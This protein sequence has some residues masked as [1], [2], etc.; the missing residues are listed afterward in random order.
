MNFSYIFH[1]NKSL[2]F[3][4]HNS[5]HKN[6]KFLKTFPFLARYRLYRKASQRTATNIYKEQMAVSMERSGMNKQEH[7]FEY[8]IASYQDLIF[9]L[10]YRMTKDYFSAEDLT[11]DTFLSAYQSLSKFDQKQERA[12]L[13]RIATNKCLDY[14]KKAERRAIPEDTCFSELPS[15]V[16]SPEEQTL[17]QEVR[18]ELFTYCQ[19][20]PDT[21]REVATDYFYYEK[22]AGEIAHNRQKSKK[23]IQTQI[24]RAK[25]M[26]RKIY[27]SKG[28]FAK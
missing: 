4:G 10:C 1:K 18:K 23:T 24:Y 21:Y 13:C 17:E 19:N 25:E 3:F 16:S 2:F 28:G 22:P 8:L 20:L 5:K 6:E 26:L 11:Q 27:Q 7:Y 15:T 9:T 12:W 14:L